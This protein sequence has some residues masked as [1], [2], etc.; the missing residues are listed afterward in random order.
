MSNSPPSS[1]YTHMQSAVD[2]VK[3]S[4]HPTN[5]IAATLASKGFALSKTNQWP[6]NIETTIGK[7]T[8]IG[9]SSGTL[10]AETACIL[11]A[12]SATK[13]ATMY[14][15]D[16]PCPNCMKNMAE[17]G[18]AKLYIDHKGFDKDWAKR[19]GDQFE[20]MSMRVAAKAGLDVHVIYRKEEKFEI[21]SRHAPDYQPNEENPA[22]INPCNDWDARLSKAKQSHAKEP[23]AL[24]LATTPSGKTVSILVDRQPTIG[25]T[26][27]TVEN[28][29]DK[30]S[31]ILQPINRLLMIAAKEGLTLNQDYIYSSRTPTSREFVNF[32]GTGL[33]KIIIGDISQSR[34]ENGIKALHQLTESKTIKILGASDA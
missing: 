25:Y 30:Y 34:D 15:T 16:P 5:K 23:F 28:K 26:Y 3:D 31:F 14:I 7:E 2:I 10:H 29:Q 6:K 33:N 17:A 32:I 21:I 18:I 12:P 8:Q 4:P 22:I 9:N 1:I 24:A 27:E 19:R 11:N 13:G 20:T